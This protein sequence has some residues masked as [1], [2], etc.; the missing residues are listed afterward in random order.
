M[1]DSLINKIKDTIPNKKELPKVMQDLLGISADSAYRRLRGETAISIDEA[2]KLSNHF[3]VALSDL[4]SFKGDHVTFIKRPFINSLE[5][6]EIFLNN[7]LAHLE[8]LLQDPNHLMLYTAK[9]IPPFYQYKFKELAAFKFYVWLRTFYDVKK[10]N[11]EYYDM[12][13]IP[14]SLLDIAKKQWEVY[15]QINAIEI[16]NDTTILS[17]INQIEYYFEAG[18]LTNKE[19]AL[20]LCDQFMELIKIVYKQAMHGRRMMPG[21]DEKPSRIKYQLYYNEVLIMDNNI[22]SR[23]NG[24]FIYNMPYAAVNY[25]STTNEE[26]AEHMYDYI[27]RQAHKSA[28]ISDVSEKER[29]KFFLKL[30]NKVDALKQRIESSNPFVF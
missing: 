7:S 19:E 16:W 3:Q 11:N 26:L 9:D 20:V 24:R 28:L 30:R 4:E 14:Q 5:R 21:N 10:I 18:L 17:L 1:Q 27:M 15:S 12:A 6:F 23:V 13:S 22:L 29:N 25:I 2:F 8:L